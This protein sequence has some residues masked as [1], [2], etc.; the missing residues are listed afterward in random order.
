MSNLE[1]KGG[2]LEMIAKIDDVETLRELKKMVSEFLGNHVQNRDYWSEL[3]E[4]ERSE[5]ELA[6]EESKDEKNL[7]NHDQIQKKFQKWLE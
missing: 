6:Y 7:V 1:L 4:I 5:V 2:L 3:N